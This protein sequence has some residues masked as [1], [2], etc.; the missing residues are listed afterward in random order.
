MA[1]VLASHVGLLPAAGS[2][3]RDAGVVLQVV[4]LGMALSV[5][6]EFAEW[7][8]DAW[9]D[10]DIFVTYSDTME[11]SASLPSGRSAG[12]FLAVLTRPRVRVR[13]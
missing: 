5:L 10:E 1:Y 13:Q 9:V 12:I 7:A 4:L 3:R 11:T 8:G 6:W 2:T